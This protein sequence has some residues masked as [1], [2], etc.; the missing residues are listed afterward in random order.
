MATKETFTSGAQ[1]EVLDKPRYDLIPPE[2][3]QALAEIYSLGA[4]KYS[5]R[6]W[7]KGIPFSVC[8]GAAKR[9]LAKFELG[10]MDN[11]DDNGYEH[12]GHAMWWLVALTTFIRRKRLDLNDLPHYNELMNKCTAEL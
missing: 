7:E 12:V 6:N 9:H 3:M 10:E 8:I 11:V 2:A 1:K 4:K 5:D